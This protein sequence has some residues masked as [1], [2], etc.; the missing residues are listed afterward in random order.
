M[1]YTDNSH[2]RLKDFNELSVGECFEYENILYIKIH[3]ENG[4]DVCNNTIEY[5]SG[6]E[7]VCV[8][9]A[10]IIFH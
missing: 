6:V 1:K 7:A 9:D 10:E 4:F 2:L 3:N 8:R 5:F